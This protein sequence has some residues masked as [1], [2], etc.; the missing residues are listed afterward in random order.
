M[1]K[2]EEAAAKVQAQNDA[3]ALEVDAVKAEVVTANR[4]LGE[5]KDLVS[6]VNDQNAVDVLNA[7][8]DKLGVE[9]GDLKT[10]VDSLTAAEQA[11]D[12]TPTILPSV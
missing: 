4:T 11:A 7:V 10:S 9:T 12:P 2:I 6:G 1:S 8:A 5:L 3:L